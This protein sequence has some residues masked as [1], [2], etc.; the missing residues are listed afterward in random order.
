MSWRAVFLFVGVFEPL[1]ALISGPGV[2]V[3]GE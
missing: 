1:R 2:E 3:V